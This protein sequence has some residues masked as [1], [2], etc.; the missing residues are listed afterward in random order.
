MTTIISDI[1]DNQ[2]QELLHCLSS[3]TTMSTTVSY[4]P[5]LLALAQSVYFGMYYPC[6]S[7]CCIRQFNTYRSIE[8]CKYKLHSQIIPQVWSILNRF[9]TTPTSQSL[10]SRSI[11]KGFIKS[12]GSLCRS[13]DSVI[14]SLGQSYSQMI[15][16]SACSIFPLYV[17]F[18]NSIK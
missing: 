14:Q 2:W 13:F 5:S 15:S 11:N 1:N 10:S 12:F 4:S 18:N 9:Q 7:T 3:S 17:T 8:Q 16:T 6:C